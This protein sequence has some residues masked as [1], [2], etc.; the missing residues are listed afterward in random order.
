[1]T[2]KIYTLSLDNKNNIPP[3]EK[4]R[5]MLF[6]TKSPLIPSALS[7]PTKVL[8]PEHKRFI[9]IQISS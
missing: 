8:F 5:C 6:N 9:P 2:K 3:R 1:M 4:K 7:L